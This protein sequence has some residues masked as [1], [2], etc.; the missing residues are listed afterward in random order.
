MLHMSGRI[1][2]EGIPGEDYDRLH[3]IQPGAMPSSEGYFARDARET[4]TQ[5]VLFDRVAEI[6]GDE[7]FAMSGMAGVIMKVALWRSV[8]SGELTHRQGAEL[9]RANELA[10]EKHI[11]K[12]DTNPRE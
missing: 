3:R 12:S 2:H 11:S 7:V 4:P 5:Q 1:G 10:I 8:E 9:E 6:V